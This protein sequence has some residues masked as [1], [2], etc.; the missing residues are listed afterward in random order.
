MDWYTFRALPLSKLERYTNKNHAR[1]VKTKSHGTVKE[2][3]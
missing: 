1:K 2:F 3:A